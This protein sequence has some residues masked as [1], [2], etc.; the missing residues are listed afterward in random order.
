[1]KTE[2]SSQA[3]RTF[4]EQIEA[5]KVQ[6][7]TIK[8]DRI[9]YTLKPQFGGRFYSIKITEP[10]DDLPN[11][12]TSHGVEL[13]NS[14]G[15]LD[16]AGILGFLL[17]S[18]LLLG[19]LAWV[20]KLSSAGGG[21]GVGAGMGKSHARVYNQGKTGFT[22]ADVAGV[23][24]AKQE[25]QEVV[26][27]LADGEKYR[28]IGAKIPK[29]VLLVGPPGTGKTLLAKAIAGEAGVPFLS[30]SGSEFV[31]LYVGVGAS[32]VRDLFNRAK[33]Q[34]PCIVF[35]DELDAIGKS[36]GSNPNFGN[37]EREQTL[38]QLLT[39]MDGFNGNEGVIVIAATN[40]PEILDPALRRPGRFDRQVLVDRPD[41]SGRWQ[42]LQV[43]ARPVRLGEDVDLEA[44]AAQTFGFSGADLAN[45]VNE[46]ALLAARHNRQAVLMADLNE[47]IE[48]VV[49]GLEKRSRVLT[50]TERQTVASHEVGH[51]LVG[52]LMPGGNKVSKI[53]IVPRGLGALGYTLQLPDS[54]RYLLLEDE[55]RGQLATLLGGRSAEEL[56]FGKVSTG[57][58]DDIQK[59]TDLAERAVTQYGMSTMGPVAFEKNS[60]QFLDGSSTRRSIS[61]EVAGEI[62]RQVQ[63][64][65]D[66]AHDMALEIL[67]LNRDLLESTTQVLLETEVLEGAPL[68]SVLSQVK[69]PVSLNAWLSG[70]A[71]RSG[72]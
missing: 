13:T 27:F 6:R 5:A 4:L 28:R 55:L 21:I 45:L 40:R 54:D 39:E 36:R 31:E 69:A 72:G 24:E 22:F 9:E 7:V 49:A 29:G 51:A 63:Q 57:A 1:M 23:D 18:G 58:S 52:A 42:I 61:A 30:M 44:I 71:V 26:D 17:S 37:D 11:L 38:N 47:A 46:A 25:L 56:I 70:G 65:I 2:T 41:K 16:T 33:R 66:Q 34:A 20:L 15:N 53:S 35:I 8:R 43:H 12:L 50:P 67:Q 14:T 32:R 60:A 62:D 64:A 10:I 48:R 68:Q 3:Y 19:A 59:A